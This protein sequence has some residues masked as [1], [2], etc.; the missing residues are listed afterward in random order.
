MPAMRPE[1]Y[2]VVLASPNH[3]GGVFSWS[4]TLKRLFADHPR[5]R[6]LLMET[7]PTVLPNSPVFDYHAPGDAEVCAILKE[8]AQAIVVPNFTHTLYGQCAALAA[9][10]LEIRCLG[11]C[12]ANHEFYHL[13]LVWYEA[14]ISQFITVSKECNYRLAGHLP[15]RRD[16]IT[17]LPYG[18]AV[19]AKLVRIWQNAPIRLTYAGRIEQEQKRVMDFVP[20]VVELLN[21]GVNFTFD[22]VG[23]GGELEVLRKGMAACP[24]GGRVRLLPRVPPDKMSGV[25]DSHDIFVQTSEYEGT[26]ISMLEAMASGTVPVVTDA[27][28]GIEGTFVAGESGFVVPVGDMH[29][30]AKTIA[31]L[32]ADSVRLQRVG[33]AAHRAAQAFSI[34]SYTEQFTQVLDQALDGQVRTLPPSHP[35]MTWRWKCD[36]LTLE[37][38]WLKT[39]I[40]KWAEAYQVLASSHH[41]HS[42]PKE[43]LKQILVRAYGSVKRLLRWLLRIDDLRQKEE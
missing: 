16:D 43:L 11:M 31:D 13:P 22:I 35:E 17:M 14:G 27:G 15:H 6:V 7:G 8:L 25:W 26:S 36:Q 10:G 38:D 39:E 20:L 32:A 24:H 1:P 40:D 2:P 3:L 28:S 42:G 12:H 29:L 9:E 23:D 34:K 18:V 33:L 37:R 19:P 30:L 4:L 41:M 21:L 5:Y